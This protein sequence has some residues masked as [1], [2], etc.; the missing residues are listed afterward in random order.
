MTFKR[1]EIKMGIK[2]TGKHG[3]KRKDKRKRERKALTERK[4][5]EMRRKV[6]LG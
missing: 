5:G 2:I 4:F 3:G 1:K 6:R